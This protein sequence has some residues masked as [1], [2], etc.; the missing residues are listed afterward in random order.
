LIAGSGKSM[1]AADL[2][3]VERKILTIVD[4]LIKTNQPVK[5]KDLFKIAKRELKFPSEEIEGAIWKLISK[6][7]IVNG[8]KLTKAT[9]MENK[10]RQE[11]L[12][13]IF[14]KPSIHIR[15][16][17][18][19]MNMGAYLTAWHL[20]ILEKF[21]YI[22]KKSQK[23]QILVF[24]FPLKEEYEDVFKVL[25]DEKVFEINEFIF[26]RESVYLSEI[27]EKFGLDA[28]T[29]QSFLNVLSSVSL[30][31]SSEKEG[32]VSYTGNEDQLKPVLEY[33]QKKD[34]E[35]EALIRKPEIP[36]TP[37][38]P[39]IETKPPELV[40]VKREY[41]YLGGNIR[42]KIAVQNNSPTM[43]SKIRVM[44]TPTDQFKFETEVKSVE[45]LEPGESR[46]ID[47]LLN[48][49]TCGKS[50]VF[51]TVSYLDAF[52]HPAS[53]TV[54][55]KEIWVKCPLVTSIKADLKDLLA[56]QSELQSGMSSI[57]F[58]GLAAQNAFEIVT[59]Q[60][61]ALDL[62]VV[63]FDDRLLKAIYS[64]IAKV[65]N[66]KIIVELE[67]YPDAVKLVV[68]AADLKQVT[69]FLAYIKNLVN[70]ALDMSKSLKVKEE[71][72]GQQILAAFEFSERLI[73]LFEYCESNWTL[74]DVITLLKE[75]LRRKERDLTNLPLD[76][77]QWLALVNPA[78]QSAQPDAAIAATTAIPLECDIYTNLEK[79]S[80]LIRSN[81]EMYKAAF[82]D[83][84]KTI[85]T[86]ETKNQ[87]LLSTLA[88]LEKKYS[89]RILTFLLIIDH[90]SGLTLFQHNFAGIE[91]DPDLISG[92]LTA[93]QS[94][95]SEL[96]AEKTEMKKL[97]YKNFEIELNIGDHVRAAL[98][99]MG[100]S[101]KWLVKTLVTFINAF[102][103][104]FGDVL[105]DWH[106]DV[107]KFATAPTLVK[108]LFNF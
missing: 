47:F 39:P 12:R 1:T 18:S 53:L 102:E 70:I 40:E 9:V 68:W 10:N 26:E 8:T 6:K 13:L 92:F 41:D 77:T 50:Q 75:I 107:S 91:L 105:K 87:Q 34:A 48:P 95:G 37:L 108:E 28:K 72:I 16:I 38:Q 99:L 55:P 61:S 96:S 83:D 32:L 74:T 25:N 97:A 62:A 52:G 64:G 71:K 57:S 22:R 42:F 7:Y 69:G 21:G 17:R 80:E 94:F 65:T 81:L 51:G 66:T 5:I 2:D 93:V 85:Q 54:A 60:I 101:S 59:S 67:T 23:N 78:A 27:M 30:I 104:K 56:W 82:H 24:P 89:K 100:S 98:F 11:M 43:I 86:I 45:T 58:T 20:Q 3:K 63:T 19:T 46:G 35:L 29:A 49:M 90:T 4:R 15:D 33:W 88:A 14:N 106:G 31:S 36:P 44:L 103:Q 79:V 73:Q 84:L 76:M